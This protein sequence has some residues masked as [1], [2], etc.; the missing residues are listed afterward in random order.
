MR[1]DDRKKERERGR[2]GEAGN[3]LGWCGV[4]SRGERTQHQPSLFVRTSPGNRDQK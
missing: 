3:S 2:G 4:E 1:S